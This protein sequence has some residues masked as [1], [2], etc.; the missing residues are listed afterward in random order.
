MAA[1]GQPHDPSMAVLVD[2]LQK[3]L[4]IQVAPQDGDVKYLVIDRIS[5]PSNLLAG[6]KEVPI[7]PGVFDRFVG[8]YAFPGNLVMTISREEN[9]FLTQMTGQP[10]FQ[11]FAT[12]ER[13][14]FLKVVDARIT[15]VTN[16]EGVATGL[17]V[18]QNGQDMSAPRMND[19]AAKALTE[20]LAQRV[21]GQ[22]PT[23]GSEAAL[24]KHIEAL[25]HDQPDYD[26][27][28]PGLAAAVRPQWA[29]V[30]RQIGGAGPLQSITFTEV[31]PDGAD[32]YQ[33]RFEKRSFEMHI[34]MDSA[35]KKIGGL[36]FKRVPAG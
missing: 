31:S 30:R 14:Y 16:D 2:S 28:E 11:I 26:D 10:Q 12:S 8:H 24:R 18:H 21:S 35:G 17:V 34:S 20:T 36:Y 23:P 6:P 19:A 25:Q 33:T 22:K 3:Q 13:E 32:I 5:S 4:G 9:R 27:M 15:F 7:E 29:A 1:S